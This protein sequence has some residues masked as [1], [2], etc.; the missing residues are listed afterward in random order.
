MIEALALA[1][2]AATLDMVRGGIGQKL[3]GSLN[4]ARKPIVMTSVALI[5]TY[6]IGYSHWAWMFI[7]WFGLAGWRAGT[8]DPMGKMVM[9]H[10]A[11]LLSDDLEKW[12]WTKNGW[13]SAAT[14][15]FIWSF[16][17]LGLMLIDP[18]WAYVTILYTLSFPIAGILSRKLFPLSERW[19]AIEGLRS[20]ICILILGMGMI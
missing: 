8:G 3:F 16:P 7:L 2:L 19:L 4:W 15:G 20:G 5:I 11:Y 13:W 1:A 14:L 10:E 6:I 18:R 17:A 9:G 12:Q